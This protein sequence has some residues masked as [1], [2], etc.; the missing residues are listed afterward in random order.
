MMTM[1][2]NDRDPA[3][4]IIL[5]VMLSVGGAACIAAGAMWGEPVLRAAAWAVATMVE[6]IR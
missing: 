1:Q 3:M 4:G 6:A 2:P 5:A